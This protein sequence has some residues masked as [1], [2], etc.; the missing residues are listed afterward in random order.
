VLSSEESLIHN[1]KLAILLFIYFNMRVPTIY[2]FL[3]LFFI[4]KASAQ[5]K[6]L[7]TFIDP[8]VQTWTVDREVNQPKKLFASLE[9]NGNLRVYDLHGRKPVFLD[10]QSE[11]E[12]GEGGNSRVSTK[13]MLRFSPGGE[14]LGP[15]RSGTGLNYIIRH[16]DAGPGA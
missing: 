2:T 4:T 13:N 9:I 15:S 1:Q 6:E 3:V 12:L 10:I 11:Q 8:V 16:L 7:S 5:Q 14:W